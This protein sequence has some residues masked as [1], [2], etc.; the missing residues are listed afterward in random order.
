L[1][2]AVIVR[3]YPMPILHVFKKL[4]FFNNDGKNLKIKDF[5]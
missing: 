5:Y 1:A 4:V 2:H 3:S